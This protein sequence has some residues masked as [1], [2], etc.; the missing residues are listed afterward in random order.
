M[1][2]MLL[3]QMRVV[4]CSGTFWISS[5]GS[6]LDDSE[7]EFWFFRIFREEGSKDL[8]NIGNL[9][10]TDDTLPNTSGHVTTKVEPVRPGRYNITL[11]TGLF[12]CIKYALC[13]SSRLF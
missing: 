10:E 8:A 2:Q 13:E 5:Y 3:F 4:P 6:I 1:K 12:A 7:S 11:F 9:N